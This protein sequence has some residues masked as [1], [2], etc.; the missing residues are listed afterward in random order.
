MRGYGNA[1]KVA[2]EGGS[3]GD[4]SWAVVNLAAAAGKPASSASSS[5]MSLRRCDEHHARRNPPLTI[6][7]Y[8]EWA[9]PTN[10]RPSPHARLLAL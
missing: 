2:I 3:A 6:A 10:Q 7:E 9:T 4:F 5:P 8:E 1:N